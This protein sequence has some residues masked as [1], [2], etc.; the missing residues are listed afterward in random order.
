MLH[1]NYLRG[2][3]N[4]YKLPVIKLYYVKKILQAEKHNIFSLQ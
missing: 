3:Y 4:K 1:N 2:N